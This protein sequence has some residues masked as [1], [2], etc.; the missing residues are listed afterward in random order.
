MEPRRETVNGSVAMVKTEIE[1]ILNNFHH[2]SHSITSENEGEPQLRYEA[3]DTIKPAMMWLS[4]VMV[5]NDSVHS[6]AMRHVAKEQN[7][8]LS[9]RTF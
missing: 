9:E 3:T 7:K 2:S 8:K 6:F 1:L 5:I 4:K